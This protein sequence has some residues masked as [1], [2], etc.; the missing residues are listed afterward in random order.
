MPKSAS[1]Y[2]QH[3]PKRE[4]PL[5][6]PLKGKGRDRAADPAR[7]QETPK[8]QGDRHGRLSLG[9]HGTALPAQDGRW[10]RDPAPT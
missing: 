10:P 6:G 8:A 9:V 5:P 2:M 4:K 3:N 7:I 1:M